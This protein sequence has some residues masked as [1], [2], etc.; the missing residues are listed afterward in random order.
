MDAHSVLRLSYVRTLGPKRNLDHR[1]FFNLGRNVNEFIQMISFFEKS[2]IKLRCEVIGIELCCC[3]QVALTCTSLL[4]IYTSVSVRGCGFGF[5]QKFWWIDGFGEKKD[6][7][8]RICIPQFTTAKIVLF[9]FSGKIRC[10]LFIMSWSY[11]VP[12]PTSHVPRPRDPTLSLPRVPA[13]PR[14]RVPASQVP[15]SQVPESQV[16]ESRSPKVANELRC[17]HK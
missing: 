2:S 12:R 13:S 3:H 4:L 17:C 14:P 11:Y 8:R 10:C 16:Q 5:Q 1:S 15:E 7:D 6:T 9:K